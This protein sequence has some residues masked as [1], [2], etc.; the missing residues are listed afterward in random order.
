MASRTPPRSHPLALVALVAGG[1]WFVLALGL[2][3]AV[4]WS[5]VR[6]DTVSELV[7]V[8][9]LWFRA[10]LLA[11]AAATA[12]VGLH[13]RSTLHPGGLGSGHG[14]LLAAAATAVAA[15]VPTDPGGLE[16]AAGWVHGAAATVAFL[17]LTASMGLATWRMRQVPGWQDASRPAAV[18][19]VLA[20]AAL[21]HLGLLLLVKQVVETA[22]Q[23]LLGL[24]ERA[25]VVA[26]IVWLMHTA[27]RGARRHF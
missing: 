16:T 3:V 21:V 24:A 23:D 14:L 4:G 19:W 17:A 12:F 27:A 8:H 6:T 2:D 26:N 10:S 1:T 7:H 15:I 5:T 22:W 20:A 18:L 13:L 11:N 9:P 25:V